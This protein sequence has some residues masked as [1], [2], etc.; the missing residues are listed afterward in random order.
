MS[1]KGYEVTSASAVV[2]T[3]TLPDTG[4]SE[5]ECWEE[6]WEDFGRIVQ[7]SAYHR[8]VQYVLV[9]KLEFTVELNMKG[10]EFTDTH[11]SQIC[12]TLYNSSPKSLVESSHTLQTE[13]LYRYVFLMISIHPLA[14]SL[15]V[16]I[17]VT[18]L[19][20]VR[21]GHGEQGEVHGDPLGGTVQRWDSV[22]RVQGE[23]GHV[24]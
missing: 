22:L 14:C 12:W 3:H 9:S 5:E 2:K 7:I 21:Q 8:E 17:T 10:R 18:V 13:Y 6:L 11:K 20:Q 1:E 24:D 4:H 15:F 16:I 23:R 19:Q